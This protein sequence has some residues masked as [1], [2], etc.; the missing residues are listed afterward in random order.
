MPL[1]LPWL[2]WLPS[3]RSPWVLT[4]H[5]PQTVLP[6]YLRRMTYRPHRTLCS[7][8]TGARVD[9]RAAGTCLKSDCTRSGGW[10]TSPPTRYRKFLA[11]ILCNNP[12]CLISHM[13]SD[14]KIIVPSPCLTTPLSTRS[15]SRFGRCADDW[16]I[17]IFFAPPSTLSNQ[18]SC[19]MFGTSSTNMMCCRNFATGFKKWILRCDEDLELSHTCNTSHRPRCTAHIECTMMLLTRESKVFR[20]AMCKKAMLLFAVFGFCFELKKT[21]QTW[22]DK[23][24][25]RTNTNKQIADKR[26]FSRVFTRVSSTSARLATPAIGSS[27]DSPSSRESCT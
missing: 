19:S 8:P 11:K 10:S 27:R 7:Q 3:C 4:R 25:K 9:A 13:C 15:V 18:A 22:K 20:L 16:C 23:R 6:H 5:Y 21:T 24:N 12:E 1:P 2:Y 14:S 17:R 26:T